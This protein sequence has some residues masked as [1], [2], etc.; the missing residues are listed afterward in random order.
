VIDGR[1]TVQGS[2][3]GSRSTSHSGLNLAPLGL[4]L[5]AKHVGHVRQQT[6]QRQQLDSDA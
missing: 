1:Q 6:E 2:E 5:S 3:A 4:P